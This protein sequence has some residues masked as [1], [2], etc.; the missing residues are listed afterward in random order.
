M[1]H[2]RERIV[3]PTTYSAEK[4]YPFPPSK[5]W[6]LL[7]NTEHLNRSL[8]LPTVTYG[9]PVSGPQGFYKPAVG[10]FPGGLRMAWREYPFDWIRDRF[11]GV[12]RLFEKGP[13]SRFYGGIEVF[14]EGGGSRVKVYAEL[15]SR[16]LMGRL[17]A[18]VIGR[19]GCRDTLKYLDTYLR[20]SRLEGEEALPRRSKGR[21]SRKAMD[22]IL[23]K[24]TEAPQE[25]LSRLRRL[26]ARGS[27]DEVRRMRPGVLAR[28]WK[29]ERLDVLRA[30]LAATR[31]G[32]LTLSW[33]LI[34]PNCRVST[35][36][37]GNFSSLDKNF[38]CDTCGVDYDAE[39]DR[40]VEL[41]FSVHPSIRRAEGVDYCLGGPYTAPHIL[42]QRHLLPGEEAAFEWDFGAE[43]LRLRA[44]RSNETVSLAPGGKGEMGLSYAGGKWS[45]GTLPVPTG[46]SRIK[47]QNQGPEAVVAV[48]EKLERDP[49]AVTAAQVALLPEFRRAFGS[50]VLAPG[51]EIGISSMTLLFT[52]LKDSTALY[53]QVGE[54]SAFGRVFKHF[55][56][57]E[58]IIAENGG[59]VVKTI[60]DAVMAAFLDPASALRAALTI[61]KEVPRFNAGLSDP[62]D[63]TLKIGLYGGP[64]I[65]VEANGRLDYF[66]RT[67]NA[68]ARV[69]GEAQ[70]RDV[71]IPAAWAKEEATAKVLREFPHEEE[72]F[73]KALKGLGGEFPLMRIRLK[74]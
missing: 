39:L 35:G 53:E 69:Q 21:T 34:C 24:L 59:T 31:G 25:P 10:R 40:S 9:L 72:A 13:L 16:G 47:V 56:F 19:K 68:A 14:P 32:L 11:Y 8:G 65:A 63:L 1:N 64:A 4:T 41:R 12:L 6:D 54:A 49:D 57:M 67:V 51:R 58:G 46:K 29:Q 30:F 71:V 45:A 42:I 27:D 43:P 62:P 33:E 37:F 5:V 3:K 73:Q 23:A 44:V 66:G 2:G 26:L 17:M 61:Q 7:G 70:G 48:L 38:H 55:E 36:S 74:P 28:R 18:P 22:G 52:D 60:G 20:L 50:E 15:T